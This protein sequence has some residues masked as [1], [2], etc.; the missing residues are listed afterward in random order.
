VREEGGG[1]KGEGWANEREGWGEY[2]TE[3]EGSGRDGTDWGAEGAIGSGE[4]A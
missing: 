1:E 3:T 4:E 2:R